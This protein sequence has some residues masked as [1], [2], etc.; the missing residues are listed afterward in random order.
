MTQSKD[1]IKNLSIFTVSF[2]LT[3]IPFLLIIA[4]R[5]IRNNN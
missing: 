2:V 5:L 1:T 4:V 3:L